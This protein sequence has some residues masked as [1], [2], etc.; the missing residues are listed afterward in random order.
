MNTKN[1]NLTTKIITIGKKVKKD[2]E[3]EK[4]N[5]NNN[6]K[7]VIES[8]NSKNNDLHYMKKK[9]NLETTFDKK[10]NLSL[11]S[12]LSSNTNQEDKTTNKSLKTTKETESN[13]LNLK[14]YKSNKKKLFLNSNKLNHNKKQ[15]KISNYTHNN[16]LLN[17]ELDKFKNRIDNIM[18]IIEDFEI[19]YIYSKESAIIKD[20]LNKIIKNKK[21]LNNY[22]NN[23]INNNLNI[24][25]N[26]IS[27]INNNVYKSKKNIKSHH[28]QIYYR[29]SNKNL[30]NKAKNN[31]KTVIL[32]HHKLNLMNNPPS[33]NN[34]SSTKNILKIKI[35]NPIISNKIKSDKNKKYNNKKELK[36]IN[37]NNKNA[38]DRR[39]IYSSLIEVKSKNKEKTTKVKEKPYDIN[40]KINTNINNKP[41]AYHFPSKSNDIKKIENIYNNN[42]K[43]KEKEVISN[44]IYINPSYNKTPKIYKFKEKINKKINKKNNKKKRKKK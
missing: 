23:N 21:Y 37:T 17:K 36:I 1:N 13:Q 29:E 26:N 8:Y 5:E 20:E 2:K 33:Q 24:N 39:I 40:K 19:K 10:N 44:T 12:F 15:K 7:K 43:N 42:K 28:K 34:C 11:F 41:M 14:Y 38:Y 18:K 35:N 30:L 31:N 32:K 6:N 9:I 3:K 27:N 4:N 16:I 22:N 25:I